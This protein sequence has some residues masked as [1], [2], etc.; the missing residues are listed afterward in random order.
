[1]KTVTRHICTHPYNTGGHL[2]ERTEEHVTKIIASQLI[3]PAQSDWVSTIVIVPKKDITRQLR[4][5]NRKLNEVAI[6]T[7]AR[8]PIWT[9]ESE[10]SVTKPCTLRCIATGVSGRSKLWRTITMRWRS[11]PSVVRS[12]RFSWSSSYSKLH[13]TPAWIGIHPLCGML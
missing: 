10:T 11:F 3:K 8:S 5:D 1:M 12:I 6:R 13:Q 9:T 4:V 2:K 7:P